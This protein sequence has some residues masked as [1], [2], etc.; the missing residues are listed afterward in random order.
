MV[1]ALAVG[2]A[3][4]TGPPRLTLLPVGFDRLTGWRSDNV[5]AALPALLKSCARLLTEPDT[6]PF[7]PMQASVDFGQVGDW[8][9]VCR[10]AGA[11]PMGN[12]EAA[13]AFFEGEFTPMSVADYGAIKGL[14]TGYFEIEL[15]G[16]RQRHG[17]YQTPLYRRP[18][19]LGIGPR[20]SRAEIDDGALA[21]RGLELL[22]VDDPIDAFFLQIQ[23]SGRIRLEDGQTI[24]LGYDGQNGLPYV[25]VGRLLIARGQIA[26][27]KLTMAS[28][29]AWMR[30][31]PEAGAALRREN[32][33]YVFFREVKGDGPVGAEKVVLTPGRS[34]AV[35]RAYIPLGAPI[36]LDAE[37]QFLP[38]TDLHR[39]LVTQDTGGA[40]KGPVRGDLFWGAGRAAGDRAGE[41]DASGRYYL[42]LPHNVADRLTAEE[43]RR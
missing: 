33:S 19:D 41:M 23:G 37:E 7:G 36:W 6:A 16:S 21:G 9:G 43:A 3:R 24:R 13:R 18:P 12:E 31:H 25:A 39:L 42:L 4:D 11:V 32:P 28:I 8:R 30:E 15:N 27:D 17:R 22:W 1:V 38:S 29:Q 14:F 5:A 34:L 20:Y 26:R 35:D 10:E 40:I 2:L